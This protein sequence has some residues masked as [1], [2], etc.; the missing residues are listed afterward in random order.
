MKSLIFK[1]AIPVLLTLAISAGVK[2]ASL[3][4]PISE[5]ATLANTQPFSDILQ[6]GAFGILLAYMYFQWKQNDRIFMAIKDLVAGLRQDNANNMQLMSQ[7]I[8]TMISAIT[9]KLDDVHGDVKD[10]Q[11]SMTREYWRY[12]KPK[13][14]VQ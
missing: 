5:Q 8:M 3:L 11:R 10:L 1:I 14:G 9:G 6:Y 4:P 2:I 7:N 12:D 13:E